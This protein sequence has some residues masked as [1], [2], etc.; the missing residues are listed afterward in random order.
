MSRKRLVA[1]VLSLA[2]VAWLPNNMRQSSWAA[3]PNTDWPMFHHDGYHLGISEDMTLAAS[4]AGGLNIRW[5]ANTG[6]ASYT[7]PAV[8]YN[9]TL[10]RTLVYQGNQSGTLAAYDAESGERVWYYKIGAQIQSSPAVVNGVVYVGASDHHLHA[11]NATTGQ[12]ICKNNAGGVIS[13]SPVV[14]NPDGGGLVVFFGQ[15]GITGSD[16][17]GAV[18]AVNAVDPN[19]ATDCGRRWIFSSFGDPPGSQPNAGSWSPPAFAV[20]RSGRPL[21]VFGSSSPDNSVY[22]LDARNGNLVW[23]FQTRTY[24]QDNDVGAGPTIS[25]P[26]V[27]GFVDGVAY[28]AG[29]N[30][31]VYALNLRTG[32]LIWEFNSRLD[33]SKV[34]GPMRST[35]AL[36]GQR[37]LLGYGAGVYALDAVTGAKIW[38]TAETAGSTPEVVSSPAVS[39][40]LGNEVLFVGDLGGRLHAYSVVDGRRLWSYRT[41]AFVYGSAALSTGKIFI[42]S[43]DGFLYAF[44]LGTGGASAQ[45][46]TSIQEP[47]AG[48]VIPN[49]NGSLGVAGSASDDVAVSK[50]LVAVKDQNTGKWWDK[51]TGTWTNVF[52]QHQANLGAPGSPSTAWSSS[53][54]APSAGGQFFAQAEAVDTH[55]QHDPLV[56]SVRFTV[57]GLGNPPETTITSPFFKQIFDFPGGVRQSFPVTITGTASD[58]GGAHPGVSKV[59]VVVKNREHNEWYCGAAGC[60]G[61]FWAPTSRW[62]MA[63]VESP[64]ATTTRWS[65]TV[66]VYDHPHSYSVTAWAEDLDGE[67]DTTRAMVSRFCVRDPGDPFCA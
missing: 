9:P 2:L 7:S 12:F 10:G 15:N 67:K 17:G 45:P 34:G 57:T 24:N 37:L 30:R 55:G 49:P 58:T 23:R 20:D 62:V 4:N 50:V 1:I 47:I 21:L 28:I 53:F 46:D 48:A 38:K 32:Q 61:G 65:I 19:A 63:S 27:N 36:L 33:S 64:G 66:P 41:G 40:P 35:A 42:A 3:P 14:A 11:V 51:A 29:K 25:L 5:Q 44:G 60:S 13:S 54:R 22:A 31:I 52:T 16:D 6:A 8:V 56:A 39:G 59:Y 43:S 18:L 26:G